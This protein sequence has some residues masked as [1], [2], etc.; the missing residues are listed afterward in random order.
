M[1]GYGV[2]KI[3]INNLI[4]MKIELYSE[5]ENIVIFIIR[6]VFIALNGKRIFYCARKG[7]IYF[8]IA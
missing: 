6:I 7:I 1:P 5:D 2:S 8:Q 3:C 4:D